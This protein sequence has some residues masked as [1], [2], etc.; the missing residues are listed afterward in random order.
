MAGSK[1]ERT[2]G[3]PVANRTISELLASRERM[4]RASSD[5]LKVDLKT[6]LMFTASASQYRDRLSSGRN[7]Q[8]AR[9]SYE[10]LLHLI[11]RVQLSVED[12]E[13]ISR[14]MRRLKA[15]LQALGEAF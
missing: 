2:F 1:E 4:N 12:S 13:I 5:F 3:H 6:A 7:R 15:E 9:R 14:G 11:P 8:A 10:V